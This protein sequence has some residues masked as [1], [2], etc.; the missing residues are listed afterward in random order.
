MTTTHPSIH[1]TD[2]YQEEIS[3]QLP[4]LQLLINM[5]WQYL[6]PAEALALRGGAPRNV[7]L[8]DV[9]TEWLAQHNDITYRGQHYPFTDGNINEAVKRLVNEVAPSLQ[10]T[11]ERV[12]E[13][14]TL[15]ISLPQTIDG[16]RKSYSLHYIDWQH[17]ERNVYHV[18][19]EFTVEK[20]GSHEAR[21]P[22]LVLFI[23]G[24]PV[25]VIECKRPDLDAGGEKAVA[26]AVSQMIRNQKPEEI[27]HLF[28]TSQLLMAISRNDA[29]YATTATPKKFWAIW[30]EEER[31]PGEMEEA[32]HNLIN[33]PLP[34]AVQDKLYGWRDYG[35]HKRQF[36]ATLGERLPTEQDR[37][38]YALLRPHR[39]L[40]L[41][42]QFIVFDDG[43]KK[44]AR[45]QQY[46]AIK[47]T[48]DRVA[49]L[50]AQGTRTGGVI[51][52]TTGSGKSLTMVMLAKALALHPNITDPRVVLVTDRVD[53]DIQLYKTFAACRKSVVQAQNGQH[54]VRLVTNR[55][56]QG[57]ARAD[58]ITTVIN[59]FEE[60]ARQQ[61][62]DEGINTFV[63]VDESHRS[64]YG[65][66]HAQMARVF[67]NAC[68]IGFT[69]TPLTKD[70]KNTAKK[71]GDFIH[72]YP[73][74]QA[75]A[76]QA[77]VPLL[78][79]GR[80]V[81]QDVDKEQLERWFERTT[82]HLSPEQKADLKRKMSRSEAVNA[83]EQRIKEIAYNIALH[84]EQNFKG[85]GL[86]G[87]V[88]TPSKAIAVKYLRYLQENGINAALVISPPDTR[89][90]HEEVDAPEE[91]VVQAF[92]R[93]MMD[94]Y[95][96][97]EAYNREIINSFGDPDGIEIIVVVDRLLT[98][99]DQPRN[100]VLYV[101]KPLKEHT[102][103]QAIARVNRL[104]E[105]K[106][107]GYIID[108]RGVLGELNEAM[109]LY[110]ALADYDVE[111][112]A[113]TVT[114]VQ[115]EIDQL[116]Q[117]H[118]AVWAVFDGVTN[119]RDAEAMERWLEPE[120]RR[121]RFYEALTDFARTL[122]VAL[123]SV[124]FY[125]QFPEAQINIYKRDL[126]HFHNLRQ[127]VKQRYAEV[128]DYHDYEEKVR[129]LMDEHVRAK[130]VVTIG[131]LVNIFDVEK[132]DEEVARLSTPAAKAD[133]ILNRMKRTISERMDEDPAFYR[134]FAEL[135][136]ET[137]LAYK[138]NRLDELEYFRQA[139]DHLEALRT[140][141]D[142]SIPTTLARYRDAPAY[143][144]VLRE[145]LV[146]CGIDEGKIAA[147]AI[148]QEA[149]IEAN[150]V[151]DWRYNLDVVKRIKRLLDD[152]FIELEQA[153][154]AMIDTTQLDLM[155]DQ[156]VE[157][158]K[159]RDSSAR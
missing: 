141:R 131:T 98:G 3:S 153:T 97:E 148:E 155:I 100:T 142:S 140:G 53:L 71:F 147:L 121:T 41:I 150:K 64:Q 42:Y 6:T 115:G 134:R 109:N 107:F 129:K 52:H 159:A 33:R 75:V 36:F 1:Y 11:N 29:L 10:T 84:Y 17:P 151:T 90:G 136:E 78:Y 94:K 54:L 86:K 120:D 35:Q 22:D 113:G 92:W 116:A 19:D 70:E 85:R 7:V 4:A 126:K 15:G 88:A 122:G 124:Q 73:M 12:Y 37:L 68:Y 112:V 39:L 133:T 62:R 48:I 139:E 137:I 50:N 149:I 59:K 55:L 25:V 83:T 40:E 23:N 74:R 44:I 16:D 145:P 132:F 152:S 91:P 24:I 5:G 128:I 67:P 125:E 14:L 95:G 51:W 63:L 79:E 47:A 80:I 96:S 45:Y 105:G 9:L 21:R 20:R 143:F 31:V 26:E 65:A 127:S 138:Q 156:I 119:K 144:G 93:R 81:E 114:D 60:A 46:F 117:R 102:L 146:A 76:D 43:T 28:Y 123:A 106:D 27:P 103:L 30:R 61:I 13:L 104:F 118:N 111:D 58:V 8:T 158:A 32:V 89:E 157:V 34:A 82:R 49:H 66:M 77:V 18:T 101:D 135:V 56:R 87:Q 57:E 38:L 2:D 72:R 154:G 99:F 110:D 108:Y 130:D 69:G